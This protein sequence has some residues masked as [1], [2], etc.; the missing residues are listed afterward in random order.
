MPF[1]ISTINYALIYTD[2]IQ[3]QYFGDKL[4]NILKMIPLKTSIDNEVVTFFDNL[5]YVPL[6]KNNFSSINFFFIIQCNLETFVTDHRP[7]TSHSIL[8]LI[9]R[10]HSF[11]EN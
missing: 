8:W 5:H 3:E 6:C 11:I 2:I 9:C 10:L 1:E 4:T 7:M